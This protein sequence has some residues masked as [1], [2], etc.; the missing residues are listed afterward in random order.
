MTDSTAI[1]LKKFAI[2]SSAAA[3]AESATFPLDLTKTRMQ[4]ANMNAQGQQV[5]PSMWRTA[6]AIVRQEKLS[7]LWQGL[8]PAVMRHV[9]YSGFRL[10]I[11]EQL[12]KRIF[13]P[14]QDGHLATWKTATCGLAA[15]ALGQLIASPT[16]LVK[17]RMQ[18]QGRDVLNGHARRYK[19]L[20]HAFVSIVRQEGWAG[21]YKGCIPNVQVT[22]RHGLLAL[23]LL[24]V[25]LTHTGI[26]H[27]RPYPLEKPPSLMPLCE[28]PVV[29]F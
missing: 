8:S 17:V 22:R 27:L 15:G 12:R 19:N 4:T 16:D 23:S 21:L 9:I 18:T 26:D 1:M 6:Y 13:T 29:L 3:M 10:S 25:E 11:Y 5:K 7:G 20:P 14:D 28:E 2:S 24:S